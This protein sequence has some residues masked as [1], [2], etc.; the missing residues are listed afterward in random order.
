MAGITGSLSLAPFWT[1]AKAL[2][3]EQNLTR[4]ANLPPSASANDE[5]FWAQ[6][7][8]AYNVIPDHINLNNGAVSP[9]PR[10]V[11]Q[12]FEEYTTTS[13]QGPSF[14]M[15]QIIG[16]KSET[17]RE[18]LAALAGCDKEEIALHRNTT[19]A[20]ET[21]IFGLP[22]ESGDE[23][24]IADLDY[25]SMKAAFYQRQRREGIVVKELKLP[26]PI[27]DAKDYVK[28]Y[29]KAITPKTK[30]LLLTHVIHIT[31]QIMPVKEI[32]EMAH[33]KGVEVI[34]DGAHSFGHL[35]FN[36]PDLNCD[37]FG[38]S[39]HKWLCAPYGTGMLYVKRDKIEKLW[40][41]FAS[42]E[43]QIADIRKFEHA[44]TG[45]IPGTIAISKAIEFHNSIGIE[46]KQARLNYLTS[47][48]VQKLESIKGFE[49]TVPEDHTCAL[50]HFKIKDFDSFKIFS[51]LFKEHQVYTMRYQFSGRVDGV[52]VTPHLFTSLEDLDR[53]T[54]GVKKIV[55]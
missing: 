34:V 14:Y 35:E 38:T 7:R 44:G 41:L 20:L 42:G 9:Q 16:R 2:E 43:D 55:G 50:S 45:N 22:L 27:V 53:F 23:A 21:V 54:D 40:P 26:L 39:L 49:L 13:N 37:Y 30:V 33:K 52:R 3:L 8:E 19:E 36:I 15:K 46:R 48:W 17:V 11:Q 25:P 5:A 24:V 28:L 32:T 29:E 18:E 1:Q 10:E 51:K 31:G 4:I 47:Y 6:I 12:I